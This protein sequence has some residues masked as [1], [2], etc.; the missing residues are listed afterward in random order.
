MAKLAC[1]SLV[2][3]AAASAQP[4]PTTD[5]EGLWVAHARYGPDVRGRLMILKRGDGL[6]ADIAGFSVPVKQRD[7]KLS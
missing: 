6:V 1:V 4:P 3:A 7:K 5:L 2:I